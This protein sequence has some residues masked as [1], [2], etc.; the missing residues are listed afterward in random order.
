[1]RDDTQEEAFPITSTPYKKL[2]TQ[3]ARGLWQLANP[4][5]REDLFI[6][7]QP[8]PGFLTY[9]YPASPLPS[10]EEWKGYVLSYAYSGTFA[11]PAP[12][13]PRHGFVESRE[14]KSASEVKEIYEKEILPIEPNGEII[15]TPTLSG[16]IS[17]VAT[18][19]GVTW[20]MGNDG[21]TGF[22]KENRTIPTPTPKDEW[23]MEILLN[24]N[25]MLGKDI[26]DTAYVEFVEHRG[27]TYLVQLRDGPEQSL[28]KNFVPET[29]KVK[30]VL[31][32]EGKTSRYQPVDL[33][34]WEKKIKA[35][36]KVP[37]TVVHLPHSSL[38]SHYAVHAITS[39]IPVWTEEGVP[40][41]IHATQK[42]PELTA[43][44]YQ[45]LKRLFSTALNHNFIE[46]RTD[47]HKG[48]SRSVLVA[49]LASIASMHTWD[50]QR[51]LLRLRAYAIVSLLRFIL[52]A[53]MGEMRHWRVQT[54]GDYE[55]KTDVTEVGFNDLEHFHYKSRD[56]VYDKALTSTLSLD[57][58][59][60]LLTTLE[61]DFNSPAWRCTADSCGY[62]GPKWAG[63]ARSGKDL[64]K[65]LKMFLKHP[66]KVK[67][68]KVILNANVAVN[69]AHNGGNVFTKWLSFSHMNILS[70]APGFGLAT[71]WVGSL[72]LKDALQKEGIAILS[73]DTRSS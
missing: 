39:G 42:L 25:G 26:K 66:T 21:A 45:M 43:K 63:V 47:N 9:V 5:R 73:A 28:D 37:G 13:V 64:A 50:G 36:K 72:V 31:S 55:M 1:M 4:I 6:Q 18:N 7:T 54:R 19:A 22:G 32:P 51:H 38:A 70:E 53:T 41:T 56:G 11:R 57:K 23:N 59:I 67:W 62:G 2:K 30:K 52:A 10:N 71:T 12:A 29:M 68:S 24:Y 15:L 69:T 65:A 27:K 14:V 35:A 17:G 46:V 16:L 40:D 3:K 8:Y 33:L 61:V 34:E 58:M 20:G 49:A 48:N 60:E 44:D